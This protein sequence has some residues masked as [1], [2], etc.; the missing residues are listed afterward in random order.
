MSLGAFSVLVAMRR[1]GQAVEKVSDLAGLA[2]TDPAMALAMAVFM[3][4]MAGIP[5]L[6]GFFA[7]LYVLLPAVQNGF[8][9]LA[10]VAVFASVVSAYYYLRVVKVMYV[11]APV[12]TFV[13]RPAGVSFVMAATG[14]LHCRLCPVLRSAGGGGRGRRCGAA[15]VRG[16][17]WRLRVVAEAP[18]TSDLLAAL[19]AEGAPAGTAVLARRQTAGRGRAGRGWESPDGNLHLS[20]L[21]R[22]EAPVLQAPLFGLAAAVAL[23]D[24]AAS[25]LPP[26]VPLRVKWP[27]DVLLADAKAG[28]ILC[29]ATAGP[30]AGLRISCWASASIWPAPR[31]CPIAP[32]PVSPPSARLPIRWPSPPGCSRRS[33]T[34]WSSWR[35]RASPRSAPL[36]LPAGRRRAAP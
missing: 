12:G 36:G 6:S 20:V 32:R 33:A 28:G 30:G 31:P 10:A 13:P 7:K 17:A 19:A 2:R 9:W 27:N 23:A 4:A 26:E 22:P 11:D 5:P 25:T 18:S 29:E 14:L 8:L 34:G 21:L 35:Q 16:I 3:F 1:E 15:R 24:T